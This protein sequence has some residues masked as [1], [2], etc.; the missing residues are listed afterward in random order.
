MEFE[1]N[2]F[3]KMI[4]RCKNSGE[5][6]NVKANKS[7]LYSHISHRIIFRMKPEHIEIFNRF[8]GS[9]KNVQSEFCKEILLDHIRRDD[10]FA[11]IVLS[12]SWMNGLKNTF[13]IS[14]LYL[15]PRN[16]LNV[17]TR[18]RREDEKIEYNLINERGLVIDR[19]VDQEEFNE[20]ISGAVKLGHRIS[21]FDMAT[22]AT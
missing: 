21:R 8:L 14:I 6:I 3:S 17:I 4:V 22:P 1:I 19:W 5:W 2:K 18:I 20:M 9:G 10:F 13:K 11:D 7:L 15:L 12:Y 16:K